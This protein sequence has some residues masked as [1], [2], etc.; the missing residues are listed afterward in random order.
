MTEER[1]IRFISRECT[2]EESRQV[3]QWIEANEKNK[4]AFVR[5]QAIWASMELVYR[6][7]YDSASTRQIIRKIRKNR[8]RT[9][10]IY[11]VA[12]AVAA[13]LLYALFIPSH[14]SY[15]IKDYEKALSE[16]SVQK[17]ITLTVHKEKKTQKFQLADSTVT[18]ANT[19]KGHILIN[20]S[21]KVI[22][23]EKRTLNTIHVP[24]GRRSFISLSDGT[25]IHLNSGS[26]LVY[27]SVFASDKREVYLDGEAYFDVARSATGKFIVQTAYRTVEVAGTKFTVLV[28]KEMQSFQTVLISGK[29]SLNGKEGVIELNPNELYSF[30]AKTQDENL[31][32]VD[33]SN[34]VSWING[35]LKFNKE[36]LHQILHK[37]EK[38]YNIDITLLKVEYTDYLVS[39]SLNLKN[40]SE[41][42]LDHLMT[43]LATD[44]KPE[45]QKFY[46]IIPAN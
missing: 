42:T 5:L 38:I 4:K 16:L 32:T 10:V 40:S 35:N 45:N 23:N 9:T 33:V 20:D 15:S 29:V 44:Y 28:D 19:S 37:L 14:Q 27:P 7:E 34:Y 31:K 13:V 8:V 11:G 21:M 46:K 41:E 1:I 24:Y 25:K 3:L 43:I 39:G 17:E 26:S 6:E 18:V 30:S 2:P 36:P 12:A 22:E